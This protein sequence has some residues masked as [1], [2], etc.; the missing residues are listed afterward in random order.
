MVSLDHDEKAAWEDSTADWTS[1][2]E[3]RA[4]EA[5]GLDVAGERTGMYL[6]MRGAVSV[7]EIILLI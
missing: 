4:T 7:P 6:S 5:I 1:D 3:E 2:L